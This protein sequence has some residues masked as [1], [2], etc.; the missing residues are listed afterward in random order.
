MVRTR[1]KPG[2]DRSDAPAILALRTPT[3]GM[4]ELEQRLEATFLRSLV[5]I[6]SGELLLLPSPDEPCGCLGRLCH[7]DGTD[8]AG[9]CDSHCLVN[10][11]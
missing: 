10:Y 8:C 6:E 1:N 4:E 2:K 11:V 5:L 3:A 7:C 9:V